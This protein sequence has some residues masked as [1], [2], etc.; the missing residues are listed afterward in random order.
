MTGSVIG[1]QSPIPCSGLL[2]RP[3]PRRTDVY[4][5]S[6]AGRVA[7]TPAATPRTLVDPAATDSR[8]DAAT[9]AGGPPPDVRDAVDAPL[10]RD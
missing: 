8:A 2:R 7:A 4:I 9:F 6:A 5:V 10:P 3:L 1:N